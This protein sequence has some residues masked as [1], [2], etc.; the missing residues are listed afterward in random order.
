[1]PSKRISL[2]A[3]QGDIV[4]LS[5]DTATYR[6]SNLTIHLLHL[7]LLEQY[8]IL[9]PKLFHY[10]HTINKAPE[11][12]Q[13]HLIF[14]DLPNKLRQYKQAMDR[15]SNQ[16]LRDK[17]AKRQRRSSYSESAD[18]KLRQQIKTLT[19][20]LAMNS[21]ELMERRLS[22]RGIHLHLST[23]FPYAQRKTLH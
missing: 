23:L 7:L 5:F 21:I 10:R 17:E 22:K 3:L 8:I 13:S 12:K 4:F 18:Q 1:M 14:S 11:H 19:I 6:L 9:A 2:L 20:L 15:A 16:K